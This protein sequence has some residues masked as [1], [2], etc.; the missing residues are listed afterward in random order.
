MKMADPATEIWMA[1]RLGLPLDW[2]AGV[3]T[4]EQ[5]RETIRLAIIESQ[6]AHQIAGKRQGR[7]PET[8][9]ALFQRVYR[10]PLEPKEV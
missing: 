9:E 4:A 1:R 5:R 8:W 10:K 6:R 3:T 2:D 7:P